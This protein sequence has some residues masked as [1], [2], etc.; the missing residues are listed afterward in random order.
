MPYSMMLRNEGSVG[1]TA[2]Q[3][4]Q[5]LEYAEQLKCTR[6]LVIYDSARDYDYFMAMDDIERCQRICQGIGLPKNHII[7]ECYDLL[8]DIDAQLAEHRAYHP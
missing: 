5:K 1:T 8:Q 2:K 4:E 6:L 3:I 7:M